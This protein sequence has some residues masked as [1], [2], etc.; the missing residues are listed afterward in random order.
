MQKPILIG[1][2]ASPFVRRIRLLLKNTG[3]EFRQINVMSKEGQE[4]LSKYGRTRRVPMYIDNEKVI[5]DSPIIASHIL[6]REFDLEEKLFMKEVDEATD[7]GLILFQLNAFELDKNRE[8]NFTKNIEGRLVRILE[9]LDS[10]VEKLEDTFGLKQVWLY[11]TLDW[12]KF[13]DVQDWSKYKNLVNFYNKFTT[14]ED[15]VKTAP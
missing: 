15:V 2:T 12:F 7:A 3:F 13:R 5:F 4:E 11:T 1:S 9:F 6:E 8:N 10:E 14:R